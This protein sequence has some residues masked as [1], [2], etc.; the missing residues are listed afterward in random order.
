MDKIWIGTSKEHGWV[1]DVEY[2]CNHGY[3]S[4]CGLLGHTVG[5]CPKKCQAQGKAP[6]ATTTTETQEAIPSK[7][8]PKERSQWMAKP[9]D[10]NVP[11]EHPTENN[12]PKVILKQ[13]EEG[14]TAVTRQALRNA[15]LLSE[16]E[17]ESQNIGTPISVTNVSEG[18][19]NG[20]KETKD[21]HTPW[22][23][24]RESKP[25]DKVKNETHSQ[26]ADITSPLSGDNTWQP[27]ENP[28]NQVS[29]VITTPTKNRFD[30][31]DTEGELQSAY[32]NLQRTELVQPLMLG[33][34][35]E[36]HEQSFSDGTCTRSKSKKGILRNSSEPNSDDDGES[37][38]AL[39]SS[40]TKQ[41]KRSS[42][43]PKGKEV[44][45]S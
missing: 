18:S 12:N 32:Q 31:L 16:E 24:T 15:G 45:P 19:I 22:N 41:R 35:P 29:G 10:G 3:C 43:E 8:N 44:K 2:E 28:T 33:P 4:Y 9:K 14:V 38:H 26:G 30:V 1:I 42:L 11:K 20:D 25:I 39:Q 17:S 5:L 36:D 27:A 23:K 6:M 40:R 21:D 7:T 37:I 13:P 34:I